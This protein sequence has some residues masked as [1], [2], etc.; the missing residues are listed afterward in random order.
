M[1]L[2]EL[3]W[4]LPSSLPPFWGCFF[5]SQLPPAHGSTRS[6]HQPGAQLSGPQSLGQTGCYILLSPWVG[7]RRVL[8]LPGLQV[9]RRHGGAIVDIP[10]SLCQV[11]LDIFMTILRRRHFIEET[12]AQRADATAHERAALTHQAAP[13]LLREIR[14]DTNNL[15]Q[16]RNR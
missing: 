4:C 3:H 5:K 12:Q 13:H 1:S 2:W 8:R 10:P 9:C 16:T 15:T 7:A 6:G 14:H 11:L